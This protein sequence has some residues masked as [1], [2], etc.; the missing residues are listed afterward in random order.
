M[1][2]RGDLEGL[3]QPVRVGSSNID[4]MIDAVLQ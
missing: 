3:R 1:P 2:Q 4:L